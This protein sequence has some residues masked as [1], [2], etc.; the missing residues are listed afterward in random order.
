MLK[1][2]PMKTRAGQLA[3]QIVAATAGAPTDTGA[4]V[5]AGAG[6]EVSQMGKL[7]KYGRIAL[8]LQGAGQ[9]PA[10]ALGA[11]QD[12]RG[13]LQ[14]EQK[15]SRQVG[16]VLKRTVRQAVGDSPFDWPDI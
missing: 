9:D 3:M 11:Y 8:S 10:S 14:P 7:E 5:G 12:I 1:I 15:V 13:I 6:A 2:A 16:G 4:E